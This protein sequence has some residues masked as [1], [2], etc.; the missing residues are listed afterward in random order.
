[1]LCHYFRLLAELEADKSI[2]DGTADSETV[3]RY[4][5]AW[6]ILSIKYGM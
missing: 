2:I 5:C 4:L 1:M 6:L 3:D